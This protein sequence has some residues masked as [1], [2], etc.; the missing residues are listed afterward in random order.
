MYGA[1]LE[2]KVILLLSGGVD[3]ICAWRLLKLPT[4]VN[5]DLST[6]P[7]GRE[8]G[9]LAWATEHFGRNYVRRSLDMRH[10]E[11]SN[12]YVPFRNALLILSAAQLDKCVALAAV[13]EWAPDKNTRFY[14]RLEKAVNRGG[15]SAGF[16][17]GLQIQA[18]FARHSKGELLVE[19]HNTF[20]RDETVLVLENTWSCYQQGAI[21]C[22]ECGGCRQRYAAERQMKLLCGMQPV[23]KFA[24]TPGKWT[25]PLPDRARWLFDNG[26]L[27]VQQMRAHRQ[28]DDAL[29]A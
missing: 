13:A 8:Q 1:V 3:S 15:K 20:G 21:H 27:G 10:Y 11:K 18:P 17:G 22:G 24:G 6:V 5:F 29:G 23:T 4:A 7:T 26:W 9:A 19:Y 12:G 25:T 14:R 16:D 28:Q 2:S